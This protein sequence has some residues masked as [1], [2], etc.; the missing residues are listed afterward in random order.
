MAVAMGLA[1]GG[2]PSVGEVADVALVVYAIIT[3]FSDDA[4]PAGVQ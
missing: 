1:F 2:I 3:T 4:A